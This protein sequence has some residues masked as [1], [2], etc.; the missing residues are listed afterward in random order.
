MP[1]SKVGGVVVLLRS[2]FDLMK[3]CEGGDELNCMHAYRT[4]IFRASSVYDKCYLSKGGSSDLFRLATI[5]LNS[6]AIYC[7]S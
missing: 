7:L 4:F 2:F 3:Y 1:R 5:F 6:K